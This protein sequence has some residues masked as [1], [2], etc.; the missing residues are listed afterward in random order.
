[1]ALAAIVISIITALITIYF[2]VIQHLR[3]TKLNQTNLESIYFN[4]MYKE[5]LIKELPVGFKYVHIDKNG[6]LK[7]TDKLISSL[8]KIWQESVYY[9][10]NDEQFYTELK[11]KCQEIEDFLLNSQ[12]NPLLEENQKIFKLKIEEGLKEIYQIVNS[13][14]LG[15]KKSRIIFSK[16]SFSNKNIFRKT[17]FTVLLF[18]FLL[19]S[20]IGIQRYFNSLEVKKLIKYSDEHS[21]EYRIEINNSITNS[22]HFEI[23]SKK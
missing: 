22:Y 10:Y 21:L 11:S 1:M 18:L 12:E 8:K 3:E 9:Q 17:I 16:I 20:L 14:F 4:D 5:I 19:V 6:V 2:S 7:N 15:T 23:Y 13:K